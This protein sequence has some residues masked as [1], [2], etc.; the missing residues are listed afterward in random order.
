MLLQYPGSEWVWSSS[1]CGHCNNYNRMSEV[2]LKDF[3]SVFDRR[4]GMYRFYFK[5]QDPDCGVVREEVSDMPTTL[6]SW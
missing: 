3:K 4:D 1:G 6:S 5:T 2:R